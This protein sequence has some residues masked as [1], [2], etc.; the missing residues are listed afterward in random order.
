[1]Q[2]VYFDYGIPK[3]TDQPVFG[4][5]EPV[6]DRFLLILDD[7]DIASTIKMTAA[8][9]YNLFVCEISNAKNYYHN[10][11]DNT[12]CENWTIGNSHSIFVSNLDHY[13]GPQPVT[14]LLSKEGSPDWPMQIE[15]DFLQMCFYWGKFFRYL[16][17]SGWYPFDRFVE[18]LYRHE[19]ITGSMSHNDHV[20]HTETKILRT[21][22]ES[23]GNTGLWD[24]CVQVI[25]SATVPIRRAFHEDFLK[26]HD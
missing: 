18:R 16:K 19:N 23:R 14:E 20:E 8:G 13:H 5:W 12:C 9:R 4:L 1:M 15:K 2:S 22:F 11:I 24:Q 6:S 25:D 3:D 17:K 7:P 21:L 10:I 26:Q